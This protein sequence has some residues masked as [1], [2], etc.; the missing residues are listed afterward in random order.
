HP[1]SQKPVRHRDWL[2][3]TTGDDPDVLVNDLLIRFAGA[4]LDQGL[5]QGEL[6]LHDE[7]FYRA[8]T[9]LYGQPFGPPDGWLSGLAA[10]L[11][12]MDV[13]RVTPLE[14]ILDSLQ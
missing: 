4:F 11:R 2:R 8:F 6:P 7:G 12:R 9:A 14:S 10:E 5:A 1:S 13:E 3:E